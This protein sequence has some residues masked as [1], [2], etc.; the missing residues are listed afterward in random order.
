MLIISSASFISGPARGL[1]GSD[2]GDSSAEVGK[3]ISPKPQSKYR[4]QK[5]KK[6]YLYVS[7]V[8]QTLQ[9]ALL[10]PGR[11]GCLFHFSL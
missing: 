4:N 9:L 7:R 3:L 10:L 8:Q 1:Y 5:I 6:Q 2:G 11:R